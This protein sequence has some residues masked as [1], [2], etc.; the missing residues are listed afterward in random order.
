MKYGIGQFAWPGSA[1]NPPLRFT[2][3][4]HDNHI[5]HIIALTKIWPTHAI[6][7]SFPKRWLNK[8][9]IPKFDS[10]I[11]GCSCPPLWPVSQRSS[12]ALARGSGKASAGFVPFADVACSP[13]LGR[14][15]LPW[16]RLTRE[17]LV[18]VGH[19]SHNTP[20][21]R[22]YKTLT[23][24]CILYIEM[25]M[26]LSKSSLLVAMKIVFLTTFGVTNN[27]Y[28]VKMT[29]FPFQLRI[30]WKNT[31]FWYRNDELIGAREIY[32]PTFVARTKLD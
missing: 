30:W 7:S 21:R 22:H 26:L 27:E 25:V 32:T 23:L 9:N 16:Q 12:T 20:N 10:E 15:R 18:S 19:G 13:G 2:P 5:S 3:M 28:L 14:N 4:P 1:R 29:T 17:S 31:G 8:E 11:P 24:E 6:K